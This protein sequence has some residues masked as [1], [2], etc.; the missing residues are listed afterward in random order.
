MFNVSP[1]FRLAIGLILLTV[2]LLLVGDMLGITPDERRAELDARKSIAEAL[3]V[4]V[5][6]DISENRVAAVVQTVE[7]LQ[8]RNDNVLSVGLRQ[9]DGRLVAAAGDHTVHWDPAVEERSTA[10]HVK[11]PIYGESGPWGVVE[12]SFVPLDSIW[13]SM[14][15]GG[16]IASVILFVALVGFGAYWLFL[17]RALSELDPSSVVPDRVRAALDVLAEGLVILDQSGRI[18]LANLAFE[19]KL[20]T[21][22]DLLVG[23]SLGALDW[24]KQEGSG[25]TAKPMPWQILI[26]V[27][28]A[29]PTSQMELRTATN[30]RL[31]FAVNCSPVKGPNGAIRGAVV[32]FDDL[33]EL[34]H[35]NGEL[36]RTLG[37]LEQ[38]QREITRQ[39]RELQVL[40]TRDPLTGVLNRRSLFEGMK[41]LLAEAAESD[42][43]LSVIMV[44]IDHF[45]SINDR[46]GHATGDKV[47]KMLAGILTQSVRA[48]DLVG[49]YGGEEFCVAL[50][51]HDEAQAAEIAEHMRLV[52]NDGKNARY[53]SALR[54]SAS[55]GVSTDWLGKM[56]S[57]ALVDLA[58]KAL[59]EAKESGRNR[60][61]C[62]SQ[63]ASDE[64]ATVHGNNADTATPSATETATVDVD[65]ET[66]ADGTTVSETVRLRARVAELEALTNQQMAEG[67]A[68]DE[69]TGL[70]NRLVLL[71]RIRQSMQRSQRDGSRLVLLS[72]DIDAIKLVRNTQGSGSAD[73]LMRMV[74]SRLRTTVRSVD[75]VAVQD[76]AELEVS[77]SSMG[78]GEFAVLLSDLADI[79]STTWI[80]QRIFAALDETAEIDGSE[81]L[82]DASIGVSV[83]PNDGDDPDVL[84]TNSAAALREAIS[85]EGR[86]VCLF[87]S[88]FMNQQSQ[89]QLRMRTQLRH[90][91]DRGE[92]FLEYQAGVDMHDERITSFEA[93][94]RWRHPE[95]GLVRPD[96]FIPIAEHASLI[97]QLGDWVFATAMRQLKAWQD[98]G[99]DKLSMSVNFSAVQ[100]RNL[101]L[102]DRVVS[103]LGEIGVDP[104]SVIVEITESTLIQ[105]LETAVAIVEGLSKAGMRIALDDFGT[106]Y[107]SLSYLNRFPIDIIKID[108]SFLQDF[109]SKANDT[110]IVSAIIAIAHS[111]GMRVVAEGVETDRQLKVLQNLQ[112]DEIQGYLFSKPISR[113]QAAELLLNPTSIR[114]IARNA[115]Q[116]GIGAVG[117]RNSAIVGVVN[118]APRRRF[119]T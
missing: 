60:V 6:T 119:G 78:H 8:K 65:V 118:Q 11:V 108:R 97:D 62:W 72:L 9:S 48:E 99:S 95:W 2:S 79:E 101:D 55:F 102:V 109:P 74:G 40:A 77:V 28:E 63:I 42:E 14:F 91:I 17:K 49:R 85:T 27:G 114:R 10:S 57:G 45:K 52:L 69:N 84:L 7:A 58:D 46:F 36:E 111:L 25:R 70:P 105:N 54:I 5:S 53:T 23:S 83:F 41:T 117:G 94:L 103:T 44:D 56:T 75:T 100:F 68:V 104:S 50:P 31:S 113:E 1:I 29:P 18:V 64:S 24:Q 107:S 32:T 21:Q 71:D 51:G 35:K 82:L 4:Q 20:G 34:E 80:V 12:V 30:E 112:C 38:S 110:E 88:K 86:N 47:I 116:A 61:V 19:R 90:A 13:S 15:R 67:I 76:G 81:I 37:K 59:Y 93:L 87:Y 73:K 16:S 96:R 26:D 106:G 22:R 3:A 33:T 92:L 39:N 66:E 43:P 89:E 115:G 98:A